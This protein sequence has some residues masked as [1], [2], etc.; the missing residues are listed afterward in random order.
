MS[1]VTPGKDDAVLVG[2]A[3][4]V[5]LRQ[6]LIDDFGSRGDLAVSLRGVF[7]EERRVD[8]CFA[9]RGHND[10]VA[11]I[12]RKRGRRRIAEPGE[13]SFV[14]IRCHWLGSLHNQDVGCLRHAASV[15]ELVP[16]GRPRF[17]VPTVTVA[18]RGVQ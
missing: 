3:K 10:D 5:E 12:Y 17:A 1:I 2:H 6:D 8:S 14:A 15:H 11:G 7:S 4:L 9:R 18:S 16:K 13:L